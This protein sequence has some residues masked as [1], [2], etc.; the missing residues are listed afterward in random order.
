MYA[1]SFIQYEQLKKQPTKSK[2]AG[3]KSEKKKDTAKDAPKAG[4]T[5]SEEKKEEKEDTGPIT[6][7]PDVVEETV[8]KEGKLESPKREEH[9]L[10]T[11]DEEK[12]DEQFNAES[13]T[14]S[15]PNHGRQP[16]LS[17]QSKMRS[18]SF[19]QASGGMPVSPS[20]G[21]SSGLAP[22]TPDGNAMSEIYRKQ[23]TRLD[24]VEKENRRLTKDLE[25]SENRWRKAE[26]ELEELRSSNAQIAE[27]KSRAETAQA[28]S[29]EINKLV[30]LPSFSIVLL[31]FF[32]TLTPTNSHL[33]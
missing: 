21:G 31:P 1:D 3:E 32:S 6:E 26:E 18:T 33:P 27:L 28:K 19:R 7:E 25:A 11:N 15:R 17:I 13:E 29:E 16:S 2:K 20:G 22:L 9:G 12:S 24:E 5:K 10:D 23:A 14:P 8:D 4:P 30:K